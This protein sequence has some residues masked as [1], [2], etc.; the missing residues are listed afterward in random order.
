MSPTHRDHRTGDHPPRLAD[1][2]LPDSTPP[3]DLPGIGVRLEALFTGTLML[4]CAGPRLW[5]WFG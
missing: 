1:H 5:G 2:A 3:H 4:L